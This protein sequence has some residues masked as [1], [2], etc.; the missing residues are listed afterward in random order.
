MH[1]VED[2]EAADVRAAA[3]CKAG[4]A[5]GKEGKH[6]KG[7]GADLDGVRGD[8]AGGVG[9]SMQRMTGRPGQSKR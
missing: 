9:V 8:E 3:Q 2:A 5:G 7:D 1:T 4:E 6:A